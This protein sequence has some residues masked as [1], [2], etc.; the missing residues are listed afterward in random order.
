MMTISLFCHS[1][2]IFLFNFRGHY[3]SIRSSTLVPE[4]FFLLLNSIEKEN[5]W[6]QGTVH[7][8]E[9]TDHFTKFLRKD[10]ISASDTRCAW[11]A[12]TTLLLRRGFLGYRGSVRSRSNLVPRAIS[13]FR[14]AGAGG[15]KKTLAK[16]RGG[17]REKLSKCA[18]FLPYPRSLCGGEITDLQT[19][20]VP[21]VGA[22][23]LSQ[24]S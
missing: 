9:M 6:A 11:H 13:A 22:T 12:L 14:M 19:E 3:F 18:L 15:T 8:Q 24:R 16:A 10:T 20:F 23:E 17:W 21:G 1:R 7:L 2:L 4:V 5:L